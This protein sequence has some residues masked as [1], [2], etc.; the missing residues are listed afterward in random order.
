MIDQIKKLKKKYPDFNSFKDQDI[1]QIFSEKE[2]A[3][4][5]VLEANHLETTLFLNENNWN[6]KAIVLPQEAQLSPV[7]A[8]SCHDFDAD[9]DL[10]IL[11]GGNLYKAKPEVGSYDASYGVYLENLGNNKFATTKSS[12][13]FSE[14]GEIRDLQVIDNQL[15]VFK[16]NDSLG[17]YKFNSK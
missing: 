7:Y 16:S 2:R 17:V 5:L 4:A 6:F 12:Q 8:I 9:G 10:D 1:S 3:T 14:K 11:L 15:W 13:G